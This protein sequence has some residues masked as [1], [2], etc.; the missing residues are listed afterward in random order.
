[1][2][3]LTE[4]GWP[5]LMK[6]AEYGGDHAKEMMSLL[7]KAGGKEGNVAQELGREETNSHDPSMR[8]RRVARAA[9]EAMAFIGLLDVFGF[10]IFEV[11]S[12]EQ[13]CINFANEK[14]QALFTKAVFL[15]TIEA[16]KA[17]G[18][19]AKEAAEEISQLIND[20]FGEEE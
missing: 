1:M 3:T 10:E 11:N 17:D 6:A 13:L 7:L 15:E 9:T 5:A 12:F 16:Y 14:L 2:D 8:A 19:D 20:L 4:V 18:I